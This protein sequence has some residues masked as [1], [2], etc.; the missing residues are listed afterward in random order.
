MKHLHKFVLLFLFLLLSTSRT[1]GAGSILVNHPNGPGK[2]QKASSASH[3]AQLQS[4]VG[5]G[6]EGLSYRG[7][8]ILLN[9]VSNGAYELQVYRIVAYGNRRI[10]SVFSSIYRSSIE[11]GYRFDSNSHRIIQHHFLFPPNSLTGWANPDDYASMTRFDWGEAYP[12]GNCPQ[13]TPI[14]SLEEVGREYLEAACLPNRDT[15]LRFGQKFV[16][17]MLS[18]RAQ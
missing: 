8:T 17:Y 13:S 9:P 4:Q 2:M 6:L 12:I 10:S 18:N 3:Q 16:D 1:E 7:F 5:G 11:Y 15:A 14:H